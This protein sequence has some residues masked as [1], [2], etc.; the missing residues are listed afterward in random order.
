MP[1]ICGVYKGSEEWQSHPVAVIKFFDLFG[2]ALLWLRAGGTV[3]V[4][5]MLDSY[6]RLGC[7]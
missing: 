3:W 4:R 6:W 7:H 2:V 1:K 5:I